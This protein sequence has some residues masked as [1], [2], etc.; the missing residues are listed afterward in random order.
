MTMPQGVV[1]DCNVYFQALISR[2]GPARKLFEHVVSGR[3]TLF[4][5]S[6][7]LD[8]LRD[9]VTRPEIKNRYR[10]PDA[11]IDVFFEEIDKCSTRLD[12]VPHVFDL[13]RDPDDAHYIDLAVAANAKLVVSRDK[14]LLS[15]RDPTTSK[16]RDLATRFPGLQ[17]VTPPE[18][19]AVL[20]QS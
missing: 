11:A 12:V 15:L 4:T 14:D 1:F 13:P 6:A 3:L 2:T 9:L 10:L 17:I 7:I 8:E 5:S 19:L 20:A 18:L 16:G